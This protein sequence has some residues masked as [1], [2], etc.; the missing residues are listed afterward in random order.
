MWN[1]KDL[2]G[3]NDKWLMLIGIP[4]GG[5]VISFMMFYEVAVDNPVGFFTINYPISI[6]YTA[7]Y[8]LVFRTTV[9]AIRKRLG[10]LEQTIKRIW[11]E[12]LLVVAVFLLIET[13]LVYTLHP[14]IM[15]YCGI[16][17]MHSVPKYFAIFLLA[18]LILSIYEA[19][20]IYSKTV[21]LQIEKEHLKQE[22]LKSQLHGLRNQVKPHFLFN[23]LNTLAS[24]IKKDPDRGVRFVEK[25]SKVYRY[26]LD[27]NEKKLIPL[28]E[29]MDYLESYWHLMKERYPDSL[30]LVLEIPE[31]YRTKMIAPFSLQLLVENAIKHNVVSTQKPLNI[32]IDINKEGYLV[33]KNNLQLKQQVLNS[34]KIGLENIR[35]RYQ[36]LSNR[37][38]R[39]LQTT[40]DFMVSLPLINLEEH[41]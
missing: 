39:I 31:A 21:M 6:L 36:F 11:V 24:L 41:L 33:V 34:T 22:K 37:P 29:E 40:T 15:R 5:L 26:L 27:S 20:Y 9:I 19:I 4:L 8:W 18:F 23:S 1:K 2:I 16:T 17:H 38:I 7:I 35:R 12:V 30:Q 25:L 14:A 32:M 10:A 13:V 28:S 3:F